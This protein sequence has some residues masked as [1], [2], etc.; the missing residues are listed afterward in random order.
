MQFS[1][2]VQVVGQAEEISHEGTRMRMNP[3]FSFVSIRADSWLLP[4]PNV[5][6]YPGA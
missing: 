1:F 4:P 6:H 5:S 3:S 2:N